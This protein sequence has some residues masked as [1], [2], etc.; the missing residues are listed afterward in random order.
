MARYR[1]IGTGFMN[2]AIYRATKLF[3]PMAEKFYIENFD[4][5]GYY[6]NRFIRWK[7]LSEFTK[8]LRAK[9]G[10]P[11]PQY[12]ILVNKGKLKRGIKVKATTKGLNVFNNVSYASE[13]ND[14]RPFIYESDKLIEDYVKHLE[15]ELTVELNAIKWL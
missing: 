2:R 4:K 5:E 8:T 9:N 10:F 15:K 1:S 3:A 13:Q 12:K 6:N 14:V 11:Y 7:D